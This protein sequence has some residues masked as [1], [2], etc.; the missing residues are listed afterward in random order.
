MPKLVISV[1]TNCCCAPRGYTDGEKLW[2]L[3]WEWDGGKQ[4]ECHAMTMNFTPLCARRRCVP[5]FP[6]H[7]PFI[8]PLLDNRFIV[9]HRRDPDQ[10]L[11]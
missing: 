8:P 7:L 5:V 9:H 11:R 6:A 3:Y 10:Q 2:K 4:K 1:A